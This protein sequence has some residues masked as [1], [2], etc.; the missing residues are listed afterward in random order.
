L[1]S[2]KTP[3][4]LLFGVPPTF[5]EFRVFG[6]LCYAYDHKSKRDKF[7]SRS[8]KCIFVGYPQGK[9]GWKLYDLDSGRY[10]VSRDVKFY[11]YEFPF[12][13]NPA[14]PTLV[15]RYIAPN[16]DSINDY[17]DNII[18]PNSPASH[19]LVTNVDPNN[20]STPNLGL[21]EPN[22]IESPIEV[23]SSVVMFEQNDELPSVDVSSLPCSHNGTSLGHS[24][25]LGEEAVATPTLSTEIAYGKGKRTKFPSTRLK[26][27]S[28]S[29]F[30][31]LIC[32]NHVLW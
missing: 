15:S 12:L 31:V 5:S 7:A 13:S 16:F 27:Y 26:G 4:E 8:R 9:K 17:G 28:P 14:S 30:S 3:Y 24:S 6:C 21:V 11:E 10:F 22:V 1:L 2:N 20:T 19:S 25:I 29:I 18:H 23:D 32:S